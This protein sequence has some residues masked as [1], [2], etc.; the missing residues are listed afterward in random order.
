M[1]LLVC[2]LWPTMYN[3]RPLLNMFD[4]PS[5]IQLAHCNNGPIAAGGL[6]IMQVGMGITIHR[7]CILTIL[8]GL[9]FNKIL[10][11]M[12]GLPLS[13]VNYR[14]YYQHV[15]MLRW[16]VCQTISMVTSSKTTGL[17]IPFSVKTIHFGTVASF[18]LR[19]NRLFSTVHTIA[20]SGDST[21]RLITPTREIKRPT[22]G[23][24]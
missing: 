5:P 9:I 18:A 11:K 7:P 21:C 6:A 10:F 20:L 12:K 17:K 3:L 15:V 14:A 16:F 19:P 4:N 23:T 2:Y 13:I 8:V 22:S 1:E 24:L